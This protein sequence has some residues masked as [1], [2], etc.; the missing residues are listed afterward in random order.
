MKQTGIKYTCDRC[1]F[2]CFVDYAKIDIDTRQYYDSG[3]ESHPRDWSYI[4][5]CYLCPDCGHIYREN[6]WKFIEKENN[7]HRGAELG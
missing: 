7:G 4:H 6:F 2:E 1:G 3:K 5:G